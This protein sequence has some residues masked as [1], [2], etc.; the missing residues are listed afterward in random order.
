MRHKR[1][2][3]RARIVNLR[4]PEHHDRHPV[5]VSHVDR[6]TAL[7]YRGRGERHTGR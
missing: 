3:C 4:L 5:T 6:S 2:H 1:P 7:T